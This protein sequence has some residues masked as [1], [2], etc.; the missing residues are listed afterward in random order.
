MNQ[1][2]EASEVWHRFKAVFGGQTTSF[3]R[4]KERQRKKQEATAEEQFAFGPHRDPIGMSD[5]LQG[6]FREYNWQGQLEQAKVINEWAELAGHQT[7]QHAQPLYVEEGK[8][9]VQCDSTAWATQLRSIRSTIIGRIHEQM[10]EA[11]IDE[12]Q[13]LNPGA[14]SWKRGPRS[15]PGRGPRDTY[16]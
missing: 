8:L 16:G 6:L 7:A 5:L 1:P 2:S 10:P 11:G 13:F 15:I 14:P 9:V 3:H 12:I 4:R